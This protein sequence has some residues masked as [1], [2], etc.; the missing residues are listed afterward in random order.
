MS[1]FRLKWYIMTFNY[2]QLEAI[3]NNIESKLYVALQAWYNYAVD[4]Y[5]QYDFELIHSDYL[6]LDHYF[7]QPYPV[8][9]YEDETLD[10]LYDMA[11]WYKNSIDLSARYQKELDEYLLMLESATEGYNIQF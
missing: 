11:L 6:L 9:G 5:S 4:T 3:C 7:S 10:A 2:E 1:E 8:A